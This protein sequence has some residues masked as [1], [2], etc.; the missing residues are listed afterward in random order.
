[1][2]P[3]L[4]S[5]HRLPPLPLCLTLFPPYHE[6]SC[7]HCVSTTHMYVYTTLYNVC[8]M[9]NCSSNTGQHNT[10]YCFPHLYVST[11]CI[12]H[13]PVTNSLLLYLSQI[14]HFYTL[15]HTHILHACIIRLLCPYLIQYTHPH[16][17]KHT[18]KAT[19]SLTHTAHTI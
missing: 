6:E 5:T 15:P 1:M 9:C 12:P 8:L 7:T 17:L 18:H 3:I 11:G 19:H 2:L 13:T 4:L 14:T 10:G 16:T